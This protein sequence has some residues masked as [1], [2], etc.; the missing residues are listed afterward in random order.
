[1]RPVVERRIQATIGTAISSLVTEASRELEGIDGVAPPGCARETGERKLIVGLEQEFLGDIIGGDDEPRHV[2]A[3]QGGDTG[4]P[5]AH[6]PPAVTDD[7][8]DLL[9]S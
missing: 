4:D 5:G 2:P 6:H 3:M 1:V 9:G 8:R 7:H